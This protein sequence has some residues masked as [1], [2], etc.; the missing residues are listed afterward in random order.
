MHTFESNISVIMETIFNDKQIHDIQCKQNFYA[1]FKT[2]G[3]ID[4][5]VM[6]IFCNSS[7]DWKW[8]SI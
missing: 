3:L 5:R 7:V 6:T 2:D 8:I 4:G 1:F